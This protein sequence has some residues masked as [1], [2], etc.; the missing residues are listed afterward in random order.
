MSCFEFRYL[1]TRKMI[2]INVKNPGNV[3]EDD[4]GVVGRGTKEQGPDETH[5]VGIA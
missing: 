1:Q 2:G 4:V 5:N 3:L